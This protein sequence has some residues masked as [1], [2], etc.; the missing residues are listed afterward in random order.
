MRNLDHAMDDDPVRT[1]R[2]DC[3]DLLRF[4]LAFWVLLAHLSGWAA[5]PDALALLMRASRAVF[6]PAFETHPAVVAFIVLSGYCVHRSGLRRGGVAIRQYAIRRVFRIAP[7]FVVATFVGAAAGLLL[8]GDKTI[9]LAGLFLKLAGISAFLPPLNRITYQG[10]APLHT[11]MVEMWLYAIYPLMILALASGWRQSSIWKFLFGVWIVGILVSRTNGAWTNWWHNGSVFGFVLYWWIGAWFVR[12]RIE[13]RRLAQLAGAWLAL[14]LLL[15][16]GVT[17]ELVVVEVRKLIF[18]GL[19][20]AAIVLMDRE[21]RL[22]VGRL[23]RAGYSLYAF[24]APVLMGLIFL[25]VPWWGV[26]AGALSAGFVAYVLVEAPLTAVGK[27]VAAER[28][29]R[30][31]ETRHAF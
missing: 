20:G 4:G 2:A 16:S 21:T 18:A 7:V 13:G 5:V 8:L 19:V 6:Q 17:N 28:G 26:L 9:S 31:A 24:H 3:L 27:R 12:G 23:G 1:S 25:G 30:A 10:N 29:G 14:T 15:M 11:V 22:P